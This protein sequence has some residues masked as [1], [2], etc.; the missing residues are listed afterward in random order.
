MW[1]PFLT[2][3][4]ADLIDGN[5]TELKTHVLSNRDDLDDVEEAQE[6]LQDDFESLLTLLGVERVENPPRLR[7][8]KVRPLG[9]EVA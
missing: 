1:L 7:K 9:Q 3:K 8:M 5:F 4:R 6:A 2:N